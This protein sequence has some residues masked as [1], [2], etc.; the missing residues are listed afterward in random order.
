MP[1][2]STARPSRRTIGLMNRQVEVMG[3][4]EARGFSLD[5]SISGCPISQPRPRMSTRGGRVIVYN[6][7]S[8]AK[9][10]IADKIKEEL[11]QTGILLDTSAQ[12]F[13]SLVSVTATFGV[14]NN[15]KDLDN[16][17]KFILDALCM[18]TIVL[19]AKLLQPRSN[20]KL[21]SPK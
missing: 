2:T 19:F 18:A 16:M 15:S 12:V 3:V 9:K 6:P 4:G 20:L 11:L 10:I 8:R 14:S 7:T 21:D 17:L 13:H 5:L 1:N